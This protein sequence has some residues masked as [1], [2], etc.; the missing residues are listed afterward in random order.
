MVDRIVGLEKTLKEREEEGLW[1]I[2]E[3]ESKL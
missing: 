2:I 1:D 3:M